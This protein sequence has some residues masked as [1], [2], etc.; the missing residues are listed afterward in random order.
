MEVEQIKNLLK[1]LKKLKKN[2]CVWLWLG[3]VLNGDWYLVA[4]RGESLNSHLASKCAKL[5]ENIRLRSVST[6]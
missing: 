6:F 2:A 3:H 5:Y 4:I 1:Y